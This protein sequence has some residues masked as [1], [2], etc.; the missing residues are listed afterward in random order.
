MH[1]ELLLGLYGLEL[2]AEFLI[3]I[4]HQFAEGVLFLVGDALIGLVFLL[5]SGGCFL[6][7][8]EV[9]LQFGHLSA[10]IALGED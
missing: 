6:E 9:W 7:I 4:Q 8:A 2:L 10:D 1:L 3:Q 5:D